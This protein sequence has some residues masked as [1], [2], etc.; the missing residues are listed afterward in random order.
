MNKKA[1][2]EHPA[3]LVLIAFLIGLIVG[4][5]LTYLIA[6]EVISFPIS[7]CNTYGY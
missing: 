5:V 4:I 3:T 7:I 2:V 6:Q 1:F